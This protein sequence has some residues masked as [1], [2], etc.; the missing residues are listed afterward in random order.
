MTIEFRTS[1]RRL[2]GALIRIIVNRINHAMARRHMEGCPQ[3]AVYAFEHVGLRINLDGRYEQSALEALA[4]FLEARNICGDGTALDI[5]ANIGNH[6][7]FL[8]GLFGRV[9][10]FEP[11]P[12]A[13]PL[14]GVNAGLRANIAVHPVAL[15]STDGVVAFRHSGSN[16]GGS[17]VAPADESNGESAGRN[18]GRDTNMISVTMRRLDDLPEATTWPIRFLK[19]DVEGHELE[20]LKGA[21]DTIA[22]HRS[23]IAFEHGVGSTANHP[24]AVPDWLRA[25]GYRFVEMRANFSLGTGPAARA[26]QIC[27]QGLFGQ[28]MHFVPVAHPSNRHHDMVLAIPDG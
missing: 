5:G 21:A 17:R 26:A 24:D 7:V 22:R 6:A 28:R 13:L 9:E 27:L 19:I 20:V 11:N 25:A 23:V 2:R 14:L 12:A 15:G 16:L 3:L 10:A 1:V 18:A 8:A 4:A